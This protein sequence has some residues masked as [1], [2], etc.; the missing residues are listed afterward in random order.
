MHLVTLKP[1]QALVARCPAC[2]GLLTV[3]ANKQKAA[4][5]V[6]FNHPKQAFNAKCP[7][8]QKDFLWSPEELQSNDIP[9]A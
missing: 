7:D 5:K 9:K 2:K 3:N 8:C 6:A 1:G 4:V